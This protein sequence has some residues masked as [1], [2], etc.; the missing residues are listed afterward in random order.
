MSEATICNALESVFELLSPAEQA[1]VSRLVNA[2]VDNVDE[3]GI[4]VE[5][6]RQWLHVVSTATA[7]NYDWHL[8]RGSAAT[9]EIGI[10]PQVKGTMIHDFW[11]PYYYYSC[12]PSL[13]NVHNIRELTGIHK[14]TGQK[15]PQDM[16]ELLLSIK[17]RVETGIPLTNGEESAFIENYD[18]CPFRFIRP[19]IPVTLGHPFRKHPAT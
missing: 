14:L 18:A 15:W 6:K 16:I 7:T 10:L 19:L 13:C 5:S 17:Q 1:I 8:R 3:T 12:K 4:R 2:E 9:R 11:K